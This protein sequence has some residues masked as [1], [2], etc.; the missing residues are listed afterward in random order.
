VG[1]VVSAAVVF[2]NPDSRTT[3]EYLIPS[4]M[5][6]KQFATLT[7]YGCVEQGQQFSFMA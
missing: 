1:T 6:W 2:L 4:D 5:E 7:V 3:L